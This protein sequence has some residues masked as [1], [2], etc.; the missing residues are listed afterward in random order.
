MTT[1]VSVSEARGAEKAHVPSAFDHIASTYDFLTGM[2]PGYLKHLRWSAERLR[3]PAEGRILDLCCGTGD[4]ALALPAATPTVA[5]I[6]ARA[7]AYIASK[8]MPQ[9]TRAR[10]DTAEQNDDDDDAPI[11]LA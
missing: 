7:A 3:A 5:D 6:E 2:N 11:P 9:T 8:T 1:T 4:V 10:Q